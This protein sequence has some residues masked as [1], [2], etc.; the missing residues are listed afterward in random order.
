MVLKYHNYGKILYM[1]VWLIRHGESEAN[2]GGRTSKPADIELTDKGREQAELMAEQ[3][4]KPPELVVTSS[5]ARALR[6]AEPLI[7]KYPAARVEQWPV[8]EFTYLS[9]GRCLKTTIDERMPMVKEY[10]KKCDPF[11]LDG[12]GAE[13][14]EG[15]MGRARQAIE[16]LK[17]TRARFAALISHQQFL[18]AVLWLLRNQEAKITP[19]TMRQ[20]YDYLIERKIRNAEI[21]RTVWE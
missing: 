10:W 14:F 2:A 1:N 20:Y 21:I 12:A 9:P 19:G 15:F 8:H 11:Y 3:F 17:N 4:D 7:R 6:T 5:F 13:T 16:R 18:T